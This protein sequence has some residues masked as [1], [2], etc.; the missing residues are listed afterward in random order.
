MSKQQQVIE[1]VFTRA[2]GQT[3]IWPPPFTL[4]TKISPQT[5]VDTV[6]PPFIKVLTSKWP[7]KIRKVRQL[8]KISSDLVFFLRWAK[9]LTSSLL[10]TSLNSRL[11]LWAAMFAI[12]SVGLPPSAACA[13]QPYCTMGPGL[14]PGLLSYSALKILQGFF[15]NNFSAP[16]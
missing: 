4:T 12:I 2:R 15:L 13:S 1:L 16:K 6:Q 9:K 11:I 14:V 3:A 5:C 7:S 10:I 8:V